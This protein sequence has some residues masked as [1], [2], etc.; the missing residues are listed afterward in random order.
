MIHLPHRNHKTRTWKLSE[1][2]LK[3]WLNPKKTRKMTISQKVQFF[4]QYTLN[5]IVLEWS[6][7]PIETI[8]F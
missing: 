8:K 5:K 2:P 1:F 6:I 4:A 3:N 7:Y